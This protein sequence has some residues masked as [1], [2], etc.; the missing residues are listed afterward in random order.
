MSFT[1]VSG[2]PVGDF[3]EP[4][5]TPIAGVDSV[6]GQMKC[7]TVSAGDTLTFKGSVE[8]DEGPGGPYNGWWWWLYEATTAH[9]YECLVYVDGDDPG[10]FT[11]TCPTFPCDWD[12]GGFSVEL[13]ATESE[14]QGPGW[15]NCELVLSF[16]F[17]L[18]VKGPRPC[19]EP[20]TF[21][22]GA[23]IDCPDNTCPSEPQDECLLD[24]GP[25][26]AMPTQH[27]SLRH[28][29]V[30]ATS[31]RSIVPTL[32]YS[33]DEDRWVFGAL[34]GDLS[35]VQ[36]GTT[37]EDT[38]R[39]AWV[40]AVPATDGTVRRYASDSSD[41]PFAAMGGHAT[42]LEKHGSGYRERIGDASVCY[43]SDGTIE[44]VERAG[45]VHR[46]TRDVG[47]VTIEANTLPAT[48]VQCGMSGDNVTNVTEYV[49][50][51]DSGWTAVSEV[52][53]SWAGDHVTEIATAPGGATT[54]F[55]YYPSGPLASVEDCGGRTTA[56]RYGEDE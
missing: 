20:P 10:P 14:S 13:W 52:G 19:P 16:P 6:T 55:S 1:V 26:A 3:R 4:S 33:P 30:R 53:V 29:V 21:A 46:Y 40:A 39:D 9:V 49:S 7:P 18:E 25:I 23:L 50:L 8:L 31:A 37:N 15:G 28:R 22:P 2:E 38:P 12:G 27:V 56:L 36:N 34:P 44:S 51:P 32:T 47:V 43:A 17:T 42:V 24:S 11:W 54:T 48:K 5:N 45:T 35:I 41:G